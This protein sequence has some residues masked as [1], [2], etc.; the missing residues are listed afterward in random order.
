MD[1]KTIV[2][3]FISSLMNYKEAYINYDSL[4][5]NKGIEIHWNLG[6]FEDEMV[7]YYNYILETKIKDYSKL[8]KNFYIVCRPLKFDWEKPFRNFENCFVFQEN[9]IVYQPDQLIFSFQNEAIKL[10]AIEINP[11]LIPNKNSKLFDFFYRTKK[12][13]NAAISTL[14]H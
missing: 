11:A 14:C 4:M 9:N 3:F 7:Q 2:L 6:E 10:S 12:I 5:Q 8:H 13:A 1:I